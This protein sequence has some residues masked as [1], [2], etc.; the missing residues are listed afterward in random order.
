MVY[1]SKEKLLKK[2]SVCSYSYGVNC[3]LFDFYEL[4]I[5]KKIAYV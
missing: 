4:T 3:V 1:H 5:W 2:H